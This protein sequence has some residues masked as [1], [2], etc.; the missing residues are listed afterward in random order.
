MANSEIPAG[1]SEIEVD[2]I[3]QLQKLYQFKNFVEALAFTNKV[4]ELAESFNHHP[5]LTTEWGK[6]RVCWWT[7]TEKGI[8]QLD[9]DMAQRCNEIQ[10]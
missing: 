5:A 4:G 6:V 10:P 3:P 8:S 7:H 1:W 9:I 2:G